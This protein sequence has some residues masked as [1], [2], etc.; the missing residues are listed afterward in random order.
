MI[1]LSLVVLMSAYNSGSWDGKL[2]VIAVRIGIVMWNG[3]IAIFVV[4]YV[5]VVN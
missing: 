5:G 3:N 1:T 4:S 2:F